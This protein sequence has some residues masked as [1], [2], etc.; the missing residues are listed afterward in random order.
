MR[1]STA[2]FV[3]AR[4]SRRATSQQQK[5]TETPLA[6]VAYYTSS[7]TACDRSEIEAV[8]EKLHENFAS[9][10]Q[11]ALKAS[12]DGNVSLS[13]SE[14]LFPSNTFPPYLGRVANGKWEIP[15]SKISSAIR[16]VARGLIHSKHLIETEDVLINTPGS[17]AVMLANC[18]WKSAP[19]FDIL[20]D[21]K[22]AVPKRK[23]K[24]D[25][26]LEK[27]KEK[28]AQEMSEYEKMRAERVA[29][30]QERLKML[31]LG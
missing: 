20:D 4:L 25:E 9:E 8:R 24:D 26:A 2:N 23:G 30:N 21:G 13:E 31:G 19:P 22:K 18:Y 11:D 29:R 10:Y 14:R 6:S 28:E 12:S 5:K 16:W 15:Q 17:G 1:P 7:E 27:Q 3:S